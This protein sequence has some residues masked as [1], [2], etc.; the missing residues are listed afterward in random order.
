MVSSNETRAA[1]GMLIQSVLS[2][3]E[4]SLACMPREVLVALQ[5]LIDS[6]LPVLDVRT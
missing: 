3:K 4:G 6:A 1:L 2:I 5:G